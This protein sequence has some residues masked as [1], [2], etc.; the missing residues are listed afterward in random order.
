M[1]NSFKGIAAAL[2]RHAVQSDVAALPCPALPQCVLLQVFCEAWNLGFP[3][4]ALHFCMFFICADIVAGTTTKPQQAQQGSNAQSNRS[5]ALTDALKSKDAK[6]IEQALAD[7]LTDSDSKSSSS[8]SSYSGQLS[9]AISNSTSSASLGT[10]KQAFSNATEAVGQ[11]L[12]GVRS[13]GMLGGGANKT[14]AEAGAGGLHH[15][16]SNSKPLL[17]WCQ[18]CD[19]F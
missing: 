8:S 10:V 2:L 5:G 12:P 3:S 4:S 9:S 15:H 14:Q 19:H 16:L 7:S 13:A 17:K 1:P 11:M 6:T 18:V